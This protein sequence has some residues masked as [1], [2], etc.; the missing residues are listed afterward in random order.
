[1][2]RPLSKEI[3]HSLITS[4]EA[5]RVEWAVVNFGQDLGR[6]CLLGPWWVHAILTEPILGLV[7]EAVNM[8]LM[9]ASC[10]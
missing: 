5:G 6:F 1:M 7:D 9:L 4:L 2:S 10:H 8:S 3:V